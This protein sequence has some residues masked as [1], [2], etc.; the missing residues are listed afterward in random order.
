MI[1]FLQFFSVHPFFSQSVKVDHNS[2]SPVMEGPSR[3]WPQVVVVVTNTQLLV[4]TQSIST[5]LET[6]SS[7]SDLFTRRPCEAYFNI[8]NVFECGVE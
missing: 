2:Q 6:R 1:G 8:W 7:H 4:C 5:H 3:H